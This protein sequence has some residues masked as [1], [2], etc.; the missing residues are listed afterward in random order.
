MCGVLL[1]V[2]LAKQGY[3]TTSPAT[4]VLRWEMSWDAKLAVIREA[5]A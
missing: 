1:A 3:Q 4:S 2:I 5:V